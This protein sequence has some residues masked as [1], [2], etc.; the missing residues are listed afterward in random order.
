M[1]QSCSIISILRKIMSET[2]ER[3]RSM[4]L[5]DAALYVFKLLTMSL[6][7][8]TSIDFNMA[9]EIVETLFGEL[10]RHHEDSVVDIE[11]NRRPWK[12]SEKDFVSEMFFSK[13]DLAS[14]NLLRIIHG[15]VEIALLKG[16]D[17]TN[18]VTFVPQYFI[19]E[20]V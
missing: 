9:N 18:P 8:W 10:M 4:K 20:N 6:S 2:D 1:I 19:G 14:L 13:A 5:R 16:G 3:L 17:R 12:L 15:M 7:K 11:Q